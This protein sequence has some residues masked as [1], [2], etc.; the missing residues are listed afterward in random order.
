MAATHKNKR[1]KHGSKRKF[2]KVTKKGTQN[3]RK[4]R[5]I[6]KQG[7]TTNSAEKDALLMKMMPHKPLNSLRRAFSK[8]DMETFKNMTPEEQEATYNNWRNIE[9][10]TRK[11]L[12]LMKR[13]N[14]GENEPLKRQKISESDEMPEVYY[15]DEIIPFDPYNPE[16]P[17]ND[18]ATTE[19]WDMEQ[20][21]R[22][23]AREPAAVK[24]KPIMNM[25]TPP[26]V[27][28]VE[29]ANFDAS[30]PYD[31]MNDLQETA[32]WENEVPVQEEEIDLDE[33]LVLE[34]IDE[35]EDK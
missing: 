7:G 26:T 24:P 33:D 22:K 20:M 18:L 1:N 25:W 6:K 23:R 3:K 15:E 9:A 5:T 28:F 14:I 8:T 21:P 16:D 34:D 11:R 12:R 31:P 19:N 4:R 32:N 35:T 17:K 10:E 30:R 13:E 29:E 2:R 27:N